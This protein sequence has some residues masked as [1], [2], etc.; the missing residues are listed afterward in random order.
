V[1][2]LQISKSHLVES[3]RLRDTGFSNL[4]L[5]KFPIRDISIIVHVINSKC[6]PELGLLVAFHAELGN[7]LDK[8]WK[9]SFTINSKCPVDRFTHPDNHFTRS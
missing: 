6:E 5:E 7:S 8:L 2:K 9:N 3:M 1:D 4:Y